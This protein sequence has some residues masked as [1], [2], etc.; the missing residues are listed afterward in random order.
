MQTREPLL[1]HCSNQE[2]YCLF[3]KSSR[4]RNCEECCAGS[5][6]AN[7]QRLELVRR[8]KLAIVQVVAPIMK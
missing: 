4:T 2:E 6:R 5:L 8:E 3:E 7:A 1:A